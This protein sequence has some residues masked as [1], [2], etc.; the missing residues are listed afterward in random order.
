MFSAMGPPIIPRPTNPTVF[1]LGW[2]L[3]AM[4]VSLSSQSADR[5]QDGVVALAQARAGAALVVG[6]TE[7]GRDRRRQRRNALPAVLDGTLEQASLAKVLVL[8]GL[9]QGL[10]DHYADVEPREAAFPF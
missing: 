2:L 4:C 6:G 8:H 10:H 7:H 1:S 5:S 3:A 9:A